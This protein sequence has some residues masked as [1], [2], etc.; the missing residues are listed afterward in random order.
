MLFPPPT[1]LEFL[2][3]LSLN[4]LWS[5]I[6][7]QSPNELHTHWKVKGQYGRRH[8]G[9]GKEGT[10]LEPLCLWT[11]SIDELFFIELRLFVAI[12]WYI[13]QSWVETTVLYKL[14]QGK[15]DPQQRLSS[16]VVSSREHLEIYKDKLVD[17]RDLSHHRNKMQSWAH[18]DDWVNGVTVR[19][20]DRW[21]FSFI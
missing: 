14:T 6:H 4:S 20:T 1:K 2:K 5:M 8:H 12:V 7:C 3:S 10:V 18:W 21:F 16:A 17:A 9:H 15:I 13:A 19:Q 11:S